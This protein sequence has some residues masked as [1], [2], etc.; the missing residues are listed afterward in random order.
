MKNCLEIHTNSLSGLDFGVS[1][2]ATPTLL[3]PNVQ[4]FASV[5]SAV[6]FWEV[7]NAPTKQTRLVLNQFAHCYTLDATQAKS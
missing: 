6:C 3:A 4:R 7:L 5:L 2:V 1:V